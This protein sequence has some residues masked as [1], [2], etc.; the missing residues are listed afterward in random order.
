[1]LEACTDSFPP[2]LPP[3]HH[4]P[5]THTPDRKGFSMSI[6]LLLIRRSIAVM[7]FATLVSIVTCRGSTRADCCN[8]CQSVCKQS[9][10][11]KPCWTPLCLGNLSEGWFDPWIAPPGTG[12][13][14]APR[15]GWL[16]TADGFFTKEYHLFYSFTSNVAEPGGTS[17]DVHTGMFQW[18]YPLSRRL[19]VGLDVPFSSMVDRPSGLPTLRNLDDI[20]VTTKVMLQE[21]QDFA[22]SAELGVRMPTGDVDMGGDVNSLIPKINFWTDMGGAWSL[23]GAIGADIPNSGTPPGASE[24]DL[25]Y[26]I[27][28]GHTVTCHNA[29]PWGDFTYYLSANG[30][31]NLDAANEH[32]FLSLTPGIRTHLCDNIFFLTGTEIPVSGPDSFDVRY[33]FMIV[34]G[35]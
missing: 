25:L 21:T 27:A 14:G 2:S 22:L 15:Q 1:M 20:T 33:L 19:W 32:T 13:S 11:C 12:S 30:R 31:T 9:C 29:T 6:I 18:Q 17:H 5:I 26:N 28:I 4:L 7:L 24:L 23:R 10:S 34:R 8:S 3:I 35:L 16:N